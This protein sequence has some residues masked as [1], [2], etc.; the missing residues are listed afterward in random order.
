MK[1]LV[2]KKRE[3]LKENSTKDPISP[4]G[5]SKLISYEIIK[6]YRNTYKLP[7]C[8]AILFNHESRIKAK[9]VC[10]KKINFYCFEN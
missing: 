8:S 2:K 3:K 1:C 6:Q 10:I 9:G 5:L 7:V 4:Y